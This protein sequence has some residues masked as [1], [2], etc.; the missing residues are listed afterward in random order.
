MTE[1]SVIKLIVLAFLFTLAAC[2]HQSLNTP[3]QYP[4]KPH[5]AIWRGTAMADTCVEQAAVRYNMLPQHIRVL[6]VDSYQGSYEMRGY[7]PRQEAFTCSFDGSGQFL[8][9]SMR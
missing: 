8:H 9:L 1:N 4:D 3:S 5:A 2:S 6:G 7:T